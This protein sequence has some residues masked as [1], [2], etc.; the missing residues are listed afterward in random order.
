MKKHRIIIAGSRTFNDYEAL[1]KSMA[2]ITALV[3]YTEIEVV[4]GTARGA[5]RL[6]ERWAEERDIPVKRFPAE[7]NKYGRSAGPK[8]NEQMAYYAT[9]LIAFWDGQSRGTK[10]MIDLGLALDLIVCVVRF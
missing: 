7:W 3:P 4:S 6:G 2:E 1:C 8:R 10:S 9:H 5:D